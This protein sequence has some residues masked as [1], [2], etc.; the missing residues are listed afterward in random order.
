MTED[1]ET[2]EVQLD[3]VNR[4]LASDTSFGYLETTDWKNQG[5]FYALM[6]IGTIIYNMYVIIFLV[7]GATVIINTTMMVIYERYREIGILGAMGM[8]PNEL[9]KLF[10]LEALFA[11]IISAVIGVSLGSAIVLVLEKVG[12]DFGS[13]YDAMDISRI[14]YPD[15]KFYHLVLMSCYTVGISALVTL[16]PC[17]K[18]ANIEPVDAINAT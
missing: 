10:F 18:A 14:T 5:E 15:L 11:G 7:L 6:G 9:V 16:L 12:I 2:A 8:K 1:P 3:A 17:R 13:S 4:L